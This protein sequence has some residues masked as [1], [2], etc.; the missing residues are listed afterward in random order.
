MNDCSYGQKYCYL[1]QN[2]KNFRI[3]P[4]INFIPVTG[5]VSLSVTNVTKNWTGNWLK[6]IGGNGNLKLDFSSLKGLNFQVPYIVAESA[7]SQDVKFLTL[8][9]NG[10]GKITLQNFGTDYRSIIIIPSLQ[11]ETSSLNGLEPTYP[12]TYSVSVLGNETSGDQDLIQKLLDQIA[13]LKSEIAKLQA[14]IAGGNN[15]TFCSVLNNNL[16]FGLS[17]SSEVRCLQQFLKGQGQDIY[18]E[19]LVTGYFGNLT[20][21]AVKRFQEKYASE[22]LAPLGLY[23]ST[24]YVGP[25]TRAKINQLLGG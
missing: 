13:Y 4:S 19:G 17:G 25:S 15:Q 2:L 11:L 18:P 16:Y 14:Q 21:S 10:K 22:I 6:F 3:S 9:E 7:G 12:F 24:G 1:N 23:H 5:S 8:D 20:L